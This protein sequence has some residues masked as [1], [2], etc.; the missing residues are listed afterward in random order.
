M[1]AAHHTRLDDG[2]FDLDF[3]L[4]LPPEVQTK[5]AEGMQAA[6]DHCDPF[7]RRIVDAA[8]V[9]VARRKHELSVDDVLDELADVN[10][11]RA[12]AGKPLVETHHLCAI[13][14]AMKRANKDGVLA[15]TDRVIRS[16]K[17][18]KNGNYHKVWAS[19]LCPK[20]KDAA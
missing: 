9:A 12:I 18:Q 5:I 1:S 2:Q 4:K 11:A 13:G 15:P 14:P 7:W 16:K 19:N 8:I 17:E 20:P 6:D 3:T 10:E